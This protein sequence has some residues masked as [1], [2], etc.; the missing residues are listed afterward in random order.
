MPI[1]TH[2][3]KPLTLFRIQHQLIADTTAEGW[4]KIPATMR[5]PARLP[6]G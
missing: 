4:Y 1:E 6:T 5:R 3:G 2:D